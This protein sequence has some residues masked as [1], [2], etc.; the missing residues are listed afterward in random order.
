MTEL[1]TIYLAKISEALARLTASE[2]FVSSYGESKDV[3]ILESGILQMRKALEA[4]A[5]AAIAPNKVQ[6]AEYRA[7]AEKN[8]DYTKDFNARSILQFLAKINPD[9]YPQPASAPINVSPGHWHFDR[10]EDKSLTK[11]KFEKF[12]DRLGKY[13]HSD[14]PWGDD[15]GLNNLAKDLPE[16]IAATRSLLSWHFTTIRAPEF[17]GVWVVEAPCNGTPPRVIVGKADGEFVVQ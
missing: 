8:T 6:Y 4:V 16:V 5:Y 7:Q 15:K 1:Q 10:R 17:S 14:N 2:G 13:L 3:F 12:Y 9:F 11:D